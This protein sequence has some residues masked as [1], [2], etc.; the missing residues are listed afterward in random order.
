M[1]DEYSKNAVNNEPTLNEKLADARKFI[2]SHKTVLLTTR[3]PNGQL[4]AR[5][6]A[7]AE[8]TPDWKFRFIYDGESYKEKEVDN[9]YVYCHSA[10]YSVCQC[11]ARWVGVYSA[12]IQ[13]TRQYRI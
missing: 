9:E 6:M 5:T 11:G 2:A 1:S 3:S 4:H 7:I 8:V 13:Q 10:A 12:D